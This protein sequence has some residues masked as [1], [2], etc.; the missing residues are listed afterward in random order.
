M[1]YYSTNGRADF[2]SFREALFRGLSPDGGLYLPEKIKTLD[3]DVFTA[4]NSYSDLAT[5][6]IQQFVE[7]EIERPQLEQ[8]CKNAFNFDAPL[9]SAGNQLKLLELF[10]GPTLAFKDFGARF[11]ARTMEYFH[12][13]EDRTLTILVATSGDTGSAVANGF[14]GIDGI[15]VVILYPSKR[16]SDIQEKQLTTLGSNIKALEIEG[17]FDDCQRLVKQAFMD[18][19]LRSHTPLS[20]ANSINI[21]RLIPQSVYYAWAWKQQDL[22]QPAIFSIPSGNFGNLSGGLLARRMGLPTEIIIASTNANDVFPK[23]LS[24]GEVTPQE[25]KHTI[26]NAMDV[27]RPSNLDRIINI[28]NHDIL[29]IKKEI[30]SWSFSDRETR[31][32]IIR[33]KEKTGYLCDPHTAVGV[34]GLERYLA[35]KN[36]GKSGIVLSTAH[37]GKFANIVEPLINET[38]NLP[39]QLKAVLSKTKQAELLSNSY[40]ELKEYLWQA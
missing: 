35:G 2:A 31:E 30:V 23:Y 34:L 7:G 15:R 38:L 18:N 28:Y 21:A 11:M 3:P 32:T 36:T 16:V 20:S 37:P 12:Q 22:K 17:S 25:S 26:S 9:V 14:Y 4:K 10:H 27:G 8:I 5:H 1:R 13:A 33:I 24:S 40:E 6:M 19:E 39:A 29:A